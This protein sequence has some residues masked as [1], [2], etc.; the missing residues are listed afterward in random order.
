MATIKDVAKLAGVS[1]STVSI[2]INGQAKT[3]KVAPETCRKVLEAVEALNYKPSITARRLRNA[4]ETK[5]TIALY[6][7]LDHR[8]AFLGSILMGIQNEIKR[9]NYNCDVV[10]CTYLNNELYKEY[11]LFSKNNY[12]AAIIGATSLKDMEFLES[13]KP[14]IPTV[15]F[16][17]Y[18][19]KYSTVCTDNYD[20]AYKAAKLIAAKG[21]ERV[22]IFTAESP[23]LAMNIRTESFI[24]ACNK[25]GIKA[26]ERFILQ[27]ENSY[28]GGA[29]AARKFVGMENRPGALFCSSDFLA[30]GASYVFNREKIK[31]PEDLEI[32]AIGMSDPKI[33]EY[34]TP[35]ITIVSIHAKE[36]AS[37]CMNILYN[38]LENK[39]KEP[40]HRLHKPKLLLRDSCRP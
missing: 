19:D 37:E 34:N 22:S 3:R 32:V 33:T 23:Y 40:V 14:H 36:M 10:V 15:L 21:H 7:P 20:S 28:E 30:L 12:S 29:I 35:P 5:P 39:I 2:V 24:E 6:W 25:L 8:T 1:V 4:E 13:I 26:E 18:S 16:N 31:I 27:V 17:R 38:I 9:L 11:D